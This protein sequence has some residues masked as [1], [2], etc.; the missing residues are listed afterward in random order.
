MIDKI[1]NCKL[2]KNMNNSQIEN[3]L[4]CSQSVFKTY[5]KDE[6]IFNINDMPKFFYVLVSGSVSICKDT[7]EGNRGIICVFSN[8]GDIFGEVYIFMDNVKYDFYC[9]V[10][11]KSVIL[12][13]P[14]DFFYVTC[15]K[16]CDFHSIL[17]QNTLT[18]LAN[19]TFNFRKKLDI[20]VGGTL[21]QKVV[22][23]LLENAEDN[24]VN[25]KMNRSDFANY[26]NVARPSLSRELSKMQKENLISISKNKITIPL[27]SALE[28]IL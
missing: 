25:M 17:I 6:I 23:F 28:E 13:I 19:K 27:L 2:F 22:K 3:I 18:I 16:S 5:E 21:R 7:K 15:N 4:D 8:N 20:I 24:V 1:N 12:K 11:K 9:V 26:F 14:K 10:N